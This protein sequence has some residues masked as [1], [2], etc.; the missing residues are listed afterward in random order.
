[1]SCS[2]ITLSGKKCKNRAVS[3]GFCH[4]HAPPASDVFAIDE[5]IVQILLSM[6]PEQL[7]LTC[8]LNRQFAKICRSQEFRR[9]YIASW[10]PTR[11]VTIMVSYSTHSHLVKHADANTN[12]IFRKYTVADLAKWDLSFYPT[13]TYE[14]ESVWQVQGDKSMNP[15][16]SLGRLVK[17]LEA[18]KI[19]YKKEGRL[20]KG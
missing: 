5:P 7:K 10:P 11:E 16:K 2:G 13:K 17:F 4:L 1:M 8:G 3:D 6:N 20:V 15:K 19:P 14:G 18:H 9:R 12:E